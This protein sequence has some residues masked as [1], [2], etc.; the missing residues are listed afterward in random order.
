MTI[1]SD[2]ENV[3]AEFCAMASH[4]WVPYRFESIVSNRWEYQTSMVTC[5]ECG[6][7]R[8]LDG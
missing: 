7:V 6:E 8:D 3:S 5:V 1:N 4:E 2:A